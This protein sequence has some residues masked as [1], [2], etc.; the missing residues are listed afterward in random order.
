MVQD[1]LND[2]QL[3]NNQGINNLSTI[4]VNNVVAEVKVAKW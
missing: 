2:D 1:K 3:I 4:D